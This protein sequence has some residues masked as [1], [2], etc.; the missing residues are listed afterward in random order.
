VLA[1]R[2][3][4]IWL[5]APAG[6]LA[7]GALR[8]RVARWTAEDARVAAANDPA[9]EIAP[10]PVA[11]VAPLPVADV[12]PGAEGGVRVLERPSVLVRTPLRP[13]R[14]ADCPAC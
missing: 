11:D 4:A 14:T 7:I 8:A 3:V 6:L 5:P 2:A 13:R 10:L 12:A 1:Y 9:A